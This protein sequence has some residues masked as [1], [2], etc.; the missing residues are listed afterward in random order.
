[1]RAGQ[2]VAL[3]KGVTVFPSGCSAPD[4]A[5]T[6]DGS[7]ALQMDQLSVTFKIKARHPVVGW[8]AR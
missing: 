4:C 1:M 3:A 8:N 5:Q 2:L 6:W 7:A